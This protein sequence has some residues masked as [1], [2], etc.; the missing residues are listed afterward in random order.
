[1]KLER[2]VK[3]ERGDPQQPNNV[4]LL[5][6]HLDRVLDALSGLHYEHRRWVLNAAMELSKGANPQITVG[7]RRRSA[8]KGGAR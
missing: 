8:K 3:Q 2:S 7:P 1:M 6:A 4:T 5:K